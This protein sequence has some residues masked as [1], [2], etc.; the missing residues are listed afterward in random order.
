MALA[1]F[2]IPT[3]RLTANRLPELGSPVLALSVFLQPKH[4]AFNN[5][6]KTLSSSLRATSTWPAFP[7][8]LCDSLVSF[9]FVIGF[10]LTLIN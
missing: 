4:G 5:G 9:Y 6:S 10:L 3:S 8:F 2:A 1:S 7:P